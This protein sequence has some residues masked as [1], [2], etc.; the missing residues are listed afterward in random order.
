MKKLLTIFGAGSLMVAAPIAVVACGNKADQVPDEDVES[1]EL[2]TIRQQFVGEVRNFIK[3]YLAYNLKSLY[4][5]VLNSDTNLFLNANNLDAFYGVSNPAGSTVAVTLTQEQKLNLVTDLEKI[6]LLVTGLKT[7]LNNLIKEQS[8]YSFLLENVDSVYDRPVLGDVV[9][10]TKNASQSGIETDAFEIFTVEIDL[11]INFNYKYNN[12][13]ES[14]FEFKQLSYLI[15]TDSFFENVIS[16]IV[17]QLPQKVYEQL[18]QTI[19][20]TNQNLLGTGQ[21]IFQTQQEQVL[22]Y[23]SNAAIFSELKNDILQLVQTISQVQVSALDFKIATARTIKSIYAQNIVADVLDDGY[24]EKALFLK[25]TPSDD[26]EAL[27]AE[28]FTTKFDKKTFVNQQNETIF[29]DINVSV[30]PNHFYSEVGYLSLGDFVLNISGVEI[31]FSELLLPYFYDT[32]ITIQT[33]LTEL[34]GLWHQTWNIKA[35]VDRYALFK[36]EQSDDVLLS[37]NFWTDLA[38]GSNT[39]NT[40]NSKKALYYG[41]VVAN[42]KFSNFYV[43]NYNGGRS[44]YGQINVEGFSVNYSGYGSS[45]ATV[46]R[47]SFFIDQL[48]IDCD[49]QKNPN[50]RNN[51]YL[52]RSIGK[53]IIER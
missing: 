47:L 32:N 15:A 19:D 40:I 23:F 9:K 17:E 41:N 37:Q 22:S 36:V 27:F 8:Q 33:G 21:G 16:E 7:Q 25:E 26:Y 6:L 20:L 42:S 11:S 30:D 38:S 52:G 45:G 28:T 43:Q 51:L 46:W 53:Y 24:I 13:L 4:S 49:F 48:R 3:D 34:F 14:E 35:S 10:I 18:R 2:A 5:S 31:D 39:F 44:P 12:N 29:K 1:D 50:Y